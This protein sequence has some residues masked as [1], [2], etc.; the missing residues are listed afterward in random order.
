MCECTALRQSQLARLGA[1]ATIETMNSPGHA[2]RVLLIGW[3]AADWKIIDPLLD[4]GALPNLN[5]LVE[6][7]VIGNIATLQPCLSPILWT[8]IATGKTADKHGITGFVEPNPEAAGLRLATSTSR[9][10]KAL[11]NILSQRDLRSIVVGWFASHPAEPIHGICV[12]NRFTED[13]P[14]DRAAV[15]PLQPSCVFPDDLA[16]TVAQL[17]LHP[18]QLQFQEL[19]AFI[20]SLK[21]IDLRTDTRPFTL[22]QGLARTASVHNVATALMEAEP[23]DC[24]G[25]YYDALDALGHDVMPYHPPQ[26]PHVSREDFQRYSGVINMLYRFHDQMLGRLLELAG[27]DTTVVLV[28]DHGFHSDHLR[29][30]SWSQGHTPETQATA[31]HRQYGVLLLHGPGIRK[32]ERVYGANLL[33]VAPTILQL[34]GLPVGRDMDGRVLTDVFE[35]PPPPIDS[36]PSWDAAPGSAFMHPPELRQDP[37]ASSAVIQRLVEMGYL[38]AGTEDEQRAVQVARAESQFNLA[39]VHLHHGRPQK[40]RE[41]LEAL[42]QDHPDEPRYALRLARACLDLGNN[43][44]ALEIADRLVAR[45]H[46]SADGDLVRIAVLLRRNMLAEA[47]KLIHEASLRYPPSASLQYLL[48]SL[49]LEQKLWSRAQ[50]EFERGLA[51]DQDFTHCHNGLAKAY[52]MQGRFHEAAECALQAIGRIYFFP[53]AHYHLGRALAEMG[54]PAR[55]IRS[56]DIAV[57]QSRH[58]ADAHRALA[59]LH[60]QMGDPLKALRHQRLAEGH[61]DFEPDPLGG[62]RRA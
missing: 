27:P 24:F 30:Q 55:A 19:S 4:A 23:W 9:T 26:L 29:P 14:L 12:S 35:N 43:E 13:P 1:S 31:W 37:Y 51:L 49:L 54:E 28:S 46:R 11:W 57:S 25:V 16:T 58:F 20:P 10:T 7:G 47:E 62:A 44:R 52:L 61:A 39:I 60:E 53:L 42:H 56:L 17:R 6:G 40:A 22:A 15:W 38:P 5:R 33:D 2:R 36:I 48:G 18:G 45:G 8:S 50:A 21:S 32:D 41:L 59:T 3:D 34:F